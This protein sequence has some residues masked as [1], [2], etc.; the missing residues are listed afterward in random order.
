MKKPIEIN[1]WGNGIADSPNVGFAEMRN[2][3]VVTHPGIIQLTPTLFQTQSSN[4]TGTFTADST[5]DILTGPSMSYTV[6]GSGYI[7]KR[8]VTVSNSGGALP[9]GLSAATLYWLLPVDSTHYKLASSFAN[10]NANTPIDITSNGS[11]TNTITTVDPGVF[12]YYAY[13]N[14]NSKLYAIDENG[15]VWQNSSTSI[16]LGI[17]WTGVGNTTLGGGN[18]LSVFKDY[19]TV[20]RANAIDFYGPLSG[21]PTWNYNPSSNFTLKGGNGQHKSLVGQDDILYWGDD[22]GSFNPFIGSLQ[23]KV[24]QTFDPTNTAT[25]TI[26]TGALILPKYKTVSSLTELGVNLMIGSAGYE[27]YP[28]DRSSATFALPIVSQE[29]NITA[30]IN[31]NNQLYFAAGTKA[32][33]YLYNGYLALPFKV[34]PKHLLTTDSSVAT[35]TSMAALG[36]KLLFPVQTVGNSGVY[37]I[38]VLT[39]ALVMENTISSG[40]V[41]TSNAVLIPAIFS[42]GTTYTVSWKHQGGDTAGNGCDMSA[43]GGTYHYPT[44]AG[45]Y[46]VTQNFDLGYVNVPENPQNAELYLNYPLATN[47]TLTLSYRTQ[48]TGAFT[49]LATFSGDN[50]TQ[51]FQSPCGSI[52]G[53]DVQFKIALVGTSS[54]TQ[55]IQTFRII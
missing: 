42:D 13:D 30:Q 16:T 54:S 23:Q 49:T 26:S 20:F 47:Q 34:F 52:T 44:S 35:I 33:T 18:G 1:N 51:A 4:T 15:R 19:L 24:G 45:A 3:D 10:A 22:D 6:D 2:V 40:V 5:T 55:Q 7:G 12:N 37:C 43:D 39:K 46:I 29:K 9:S 27:I 50:S 48:L 8:I 17:L 21:S 31:I 36:R 28:W 25:Y 53:T 41:G 14:A 38:D 11:G 32:N